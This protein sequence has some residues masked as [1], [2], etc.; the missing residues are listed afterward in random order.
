M[1]KADEI[2]HSRIEIKTRACKRKRNLFIQWGFCQAEA[3][4]IGF[5]LDLSLAISKKSALLWPSLDT[6]PPPS[7]KN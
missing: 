4:S 7:N 3:A 5:T 2:A 1:A 6:A